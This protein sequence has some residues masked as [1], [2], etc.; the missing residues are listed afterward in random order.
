LN[1]ACVAE[2][3]LTLH[4]TKSGIKRTF[5]LPSIETGIDNQGS[6]LTMESSND[7]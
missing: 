2:F 3:A 1:L 5:G 6:Y 4:L 7:K